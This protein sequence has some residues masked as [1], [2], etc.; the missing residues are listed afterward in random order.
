MKLYL[1]KS[2]VNRSILTRL[3]KVTKLSF[4]ETRDCSQNF[5]AA[6]KRSLH[7]SRYGL[8]VVR[9]GVGFHP[10]SSAADARKPNRSVCLLQI[11]FPTAYLDVTRWLRVIR[12]QHIPF[13]CFH[14]KQFIGRV[15][16]QEASTMKSL[17]P[18]LR[19]ASY[20]TATSLTEGGFKAPLRRPDSSQPV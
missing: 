9:S 7:T 14:F 6:S 2:K 8:F 1:R 4:P 12:G 19:R 18:A 11:P 17:E 10:V 13:I 15:Q 3:S 20:H 5:P 16:K